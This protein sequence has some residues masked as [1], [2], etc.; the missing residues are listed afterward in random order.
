MEIKYPPA[1]TLF[2]GRLVFP[3]TKELVG[4][5]L[6]LQFQGIQVSVASK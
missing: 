1:R 5:P 3:I 2:D 6:K 4:Q